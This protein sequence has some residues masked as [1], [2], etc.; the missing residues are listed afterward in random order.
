MKKGIAACEA[1]LLEDLDIKML[2]DFQFKK[3]VAQPKETIKEINES[4]GIGFTPDV[5]QALDSTLN[6]SNSPKKV[7]FVVPDEWSTCDRDE[8]GKWCCFNKDNFNDDILFIG[9]WNG[10][11]LRLVQFFFQRVSLNGLH[12]FNCELRACV[13]PTI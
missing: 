2:L 4:F 7:K 6:D 10:K 8:I 5:E 11:A 1:W 3:L 12:H 13:H 9:F